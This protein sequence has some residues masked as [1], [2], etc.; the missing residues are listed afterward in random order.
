MVD[1]ALLQMDMEK[2]D[3]PDMLVIDSDDE[4]IPILESEMTTKPEGVHFVAKACKAVATKPNVIDGKTAAIPASV[5]TQLVKYESTPAYLYIC[6]YC[7]KKMT[8][9]V[10]LMY[11]HWRE[12]HK[13]KSRNSG[14]L[15]N[16]DEPFVFYVDVNLRCEVCTNFT[17]IPKRSYRNHF[18]RLHAK[19][20][21]IAMTECQNRKVCGLCSFSSPDLLRSDHFATVHPID[22]LGDLTLL[23]RPLVPISDANLYELLFL[24]N[25]QPHKCLYCNEV[26]SCKDDYEQHHQQAHEKMPPLMRVL[27]TPPR[28]GCTICSMTADTEQAVVQHLQHHNLY[29]FHKKYQCVYCEAAF[30]AKVCVQDHC[31]RAHDKNTNE[32]RL[33]PIETRLDV[34]RRIKIIFTNGLM[35]CK[36]EVK[37]SKYGDMSDIIAEIAEIEAIELAEQQRV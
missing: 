33:T 28:F 25:Q 10:D 1:H 17:R 15:L 4:I 18:K 23:N 12:T 22:T 19:C 24:G 26:L 31:V 14:Q 9:T 30:A 5:M 27:T 34:Y 32:W 21:S 29:K 37:D 8:N 16:D 35:V 11:A 3:D 13:Y 7:P 20:Q 36:E 6:K 2:N